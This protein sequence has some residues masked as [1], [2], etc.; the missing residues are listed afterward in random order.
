MFYQ[1]VSFSAW[2]DFSQTKSRDVIL[3]MCWGNC[4]TLSSV[5]KLHNCFVATNTFTFKR[6]NPLIYWRRRRRSQVSL[7]CSVLSV[8]VFSP[9][10]FKLK[11]FL[12]DNET[13]SSFLLRNAS[14]PEHSVQQITE[15]DINLQKVRRHSA[16]AQSVSPTWIRAAGGILLQLSFMR[17]LTVWSKTIHNMQDKKL[18]D[19]RWK[20]ENIGK[21]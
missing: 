3:K 16:H 11:H 12:R 10:G 9:T 14:F 18:T 19:I 20:S 15:A 21:I 13:L 17:K 4:F 5:K 2:T 6:Q 8:F 7:T 1:P